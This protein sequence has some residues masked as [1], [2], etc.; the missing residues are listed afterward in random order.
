MNQAEKTAQKAQL[1]DE[2]D[3]LKVSTFFV[4]NLC[5]GS[6]VGFDYRGSLHSVLSSFDE[7]TRQTG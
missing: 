3:L 5:V 4:P 6:S 2:A 1:G 7:Q